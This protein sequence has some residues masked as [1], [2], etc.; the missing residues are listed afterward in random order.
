MRLPLEC[1][2]CVRTKTAEEPAGMGTVLNEFRHG[3]QVGVS[4]R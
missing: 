4:V 2:G 1:S 3:R